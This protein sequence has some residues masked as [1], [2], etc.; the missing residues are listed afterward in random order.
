MNA[1][2]ERR[3]LGPISVREVE[4][5]VEVAKGLTN[6]KIGGCLG[7]SG[8]TVKNHMIHIVAKLGAKD[9]TSAVVIA[10]RKGLLHLGCWES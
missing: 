1:V 7:V 6:E 3:K 9:R 2:Y 5:L 10:H 4:V 8:Q